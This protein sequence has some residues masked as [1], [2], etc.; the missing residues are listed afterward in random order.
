MARWC[1]RHGTKVRQWFRKNRCGQPILEG[2]VRSMLRLRL[3]STRSRYI[4]RYSEFSGVCRTLAKLLRG[5]EAPNGLEPLDKGF[6]DLSLSHLGTAPHYYQANR[7]IV[8]ETV[9]LGKAREVVPGIP[10]RH[11]APPQV[12]TA[13]PGEHISN[14]L[15]FLESSRKRQVRR[16]YFTG[17]TDEFVVHRHDRRPVR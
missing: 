3:L 15:L 5:L 9:A 17:G 10:S 11:R 6:A 12:S 16:R 1:R 14:L 8:G 13:S 4:Y 7:L 2:L